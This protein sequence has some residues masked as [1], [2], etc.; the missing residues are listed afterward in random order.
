M[1]KIMATEEELRR[2][3]KIRKRKQRQRAREKKL[4]GKSADRIDKRSSAV[5]EYYMAKEVMEDGL[6]EIKSTSD[7]AEEKNKNVPYAI[8]YTGSGRPPKR[9]GVTERLREVLGAPAIHVEEYKEY[10][11]LSGLDAS[12]TTVRDC[13]VHNI[14]HWALK[15]S[16][17]HM[18][19]LLERIDGKVPQKLVATVGNQMSITD[20]VAML[21]LGEDEYSVE[22]DE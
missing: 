14:L 12:R 7:L 4:E 22:G 19:E 3:E 16:A 9:A 2:R 8:G 18:K 1:S 6:N 13:V 15:G 5:A 10:C 17:P 20:A 11:E 21:E